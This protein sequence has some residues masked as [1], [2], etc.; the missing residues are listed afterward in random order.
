MPRS[1]EPD[2]LAQYDRFTLGGKDRGPYRPV[3]FLGAAV[4]NGGVHADHHAAGIDNGA[5]GVSGVHGGVGLEV[6]GVAAQHANPSGR[7]AASQSGDDPLAHGELE[8]EG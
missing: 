5:A 6:V 7:L 3:F 8:A 1:K 2:P 4:G